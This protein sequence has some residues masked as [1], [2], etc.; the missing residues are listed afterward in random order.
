MLDP[1]ELVAIGAAGVAA[2]AVNAV[3]G[4]GSLITFPLLVATGLPALT[5]NLSNTIAQLPGYASIVTGYRAELAGQRSRIVRLGA[6]ALLGG[7]AGI[8]ALKLGSKGT[9]AIVAPVCVLLASALLAAQPVVARRVAARR[10]PD[11]PPRPAH[12]GPA[13]MAALA[14]AGAYCSYFGAGGGV[15]LLALLALS[16]DDTLQRLNAFNRYLV[17][18]VNI[19]AAAVYAVL[20]P[21]DWTVVAVL[22]PSTLL[23]GW[24]GVGIARRLDDR[25]LRALVVLFGVVAGVVLF[26]T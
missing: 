16:V 25:L 24:Y 2:G 23:G 18:V 3:A 12:G 19:M 13:L 7:V 26:V 10:G 20:G 1:A 6:I 4:G 17:L 21:V 15:V 8:A 22:A 14:V 9:F 5:A 11:A